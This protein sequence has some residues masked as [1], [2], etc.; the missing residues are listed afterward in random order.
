MKRNRLP[1]GAV[2]FF[3]YSPATPR[4]CAPVPLCSLWRHSTAE[5]DTRSRRCS[6]LARACAALCALCLDRSSLRQCTLRSQQQRRM[7]PRPSASVHRASAQSLVGKEGCAVCD[8]RCLLD[9]GRMRAEPLR[10]DGMS[11]SFSF[12]RSARLDAKSRASVISRQCWKYKSLNAHRS[13]A[14]HC[15]SLRRASCRMSA[16]PV[17]A[18][19]VHAGL[20]VVIV[21]VQTSCMTRLSS[22]SD[23]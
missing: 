10:H 1:G 7:K 6:E 18:S 23:N 8:V 21:F 13:I 9:G 16:C 17:P 22:L 14:R 12:C 15:P 11:F 4:P 5:T 19:I 20:V 2:P 3:P